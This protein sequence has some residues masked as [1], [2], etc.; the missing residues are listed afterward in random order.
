MVS[1]ENSDLDDFVDELV[2]DANCCCKG[3]ACEDCCD[4]ELCDDDKGDTMGT[5]VVDNAIS[6]IS[7]GQCR[8]LIFVS[9][10]AVA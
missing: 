7:G 8:S 5:I 1:F 2:L 3:L 4:K 10:C 9:I 6:M